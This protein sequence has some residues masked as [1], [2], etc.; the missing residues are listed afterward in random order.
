VSEPLVTDEDVKEIIETD[1]DIVLLPF[2]RTAHILVEVHLLSVITNSE[3]LKEIE[4]WLSA[5]FYAIRAPLAQSESVGGLSQTY[6]MT[7]GKGLEQ[8]TYGQQA[9]ALDHTGTLKK[10]SDGERRKGSLQVI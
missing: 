10:L 3:L 7:G 9:I 2:R 1:S 4:R 6:L 5:H 8:T